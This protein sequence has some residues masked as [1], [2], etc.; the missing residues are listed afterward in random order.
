[1][2]EKEIEVNK[3]F[4]KKGIDLSLISAENPETG[5]IS[6]QVCNQLDNQVMI[7]IATV[8]R[9]IT[10]TIAKSL[11]EHNTIPNKVQ[12]GLIFQYFFDRAVEIFYKRFNGIETDSVS[13]DIQEVFDYYEPDLPYNVQQIL[14]NRVNNI[15]ALTSDLWSFMGNAGIFETPFNEWF[16][17]FLSVATTIGLRFAQ[18][19][20]FNDES[21]LNAFLNID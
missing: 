21:E 17:N 10:R 13:F 14:T 2:T 12:S 16:S 3:A 9:S 19:I 4:I 8:L 5:F 1:M 20:D 6:G 18:E 11:E 7:E 15:V